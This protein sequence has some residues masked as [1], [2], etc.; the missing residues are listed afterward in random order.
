MFAAHECP[1]YK[2]G[3]PE[4]ADIRGLKQLQPRRHRT[5]S[6]HKQMIEGDLE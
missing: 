2:D 1:R 4:I 3:T 5:K 6:D